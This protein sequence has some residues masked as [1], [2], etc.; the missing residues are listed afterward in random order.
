[1]AP[2]LFAAFA[3]A[4]W[5]EWRVAR[6]ELTRDRDPALPL[7]DTGGHPSRH[8]FEPLDLVQANRP[9]HQAPRPGEHVGQHDRSLSRASLASSFAVATEGS[10]QACRSRGCQYSRQPVTFLNVS[11]RVARRFWI[12]TRAA[13]M[14]VPSLPS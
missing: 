10:N 9:A 6:A 7:W 12:S 1:L 2:G 13:G 5:T 11:V 3:A 4:C 14:G 8:R